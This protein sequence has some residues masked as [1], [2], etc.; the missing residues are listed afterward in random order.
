MGA[1]DGHG[2]PEV[3]RVRGGGLGDHG[4]RR[5]G[6]VGPGVEPDGRRAGFGR[7]GIGRAHDQQPAAQ[8][9]R[10]PELVVGHQVLGLQPRVERPEVVVGCPG[11]PEV[12]GSGIGVG[13]PGFSGR[14]DAELVAV[15]GHGVAEEGI[16]D[17]LGCRQAGDA[18]PVVGPAL[19]AP[20]HVPAAGRGQRGDGLPRRAHRQRVAAEVHGVA[21]QLGRAGIRAG[22]HLHLP[23]G[24]GPALVALENPHPPAGAADQD[25]RV[26]V[27]RAD[28]EAVAAEGEGRAELRR[29]RGRIDVGRGQDAGHAPVV[30]PALVAFVNIDRAEVGEGGAAHRSRAAR[31][32]DRHAV[33]LDRH[34]RAEVVAARLA[35]PLLHQHP[36]AEEERRPG[37]SPR[38]RRVVQRG[39]HQQVGAVQRDGVAETDAVGAERI[40]HRQP[41]NG[42]GNRGI[43]FHHPGIDHRRRHA[44]A[45]GV[46]HRKSDTVEAQRA[47]VVAV[48]FCG[49]ALVEDSRLAPGVVAAAVPAIRADGAGACDGGGPGVGV[50]VDV[51][52]R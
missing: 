6:L 1:V 26:L 18:A 7:R 13:P 40:G 24:V 31:R 14:A 23:P 4:P 50:V 22:K 44:V 51:L 46:S 48:G 37:R 38:H 39:P 19:V 28:H 15:E 34:G 5:R 41:Q 36:V 45:F 9:E 2:G 52:A 49:G 20:E 12:G 11:R 33:A 27:R 16:G 29:G 32:A 8:A 17:G 47:A 43:D 35:Q 3:V 10:S 30:G 25:Q 42:A 21:E